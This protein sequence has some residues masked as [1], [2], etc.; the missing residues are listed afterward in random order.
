MIDLGLPPGPDVGAVLR[1]VDQAR[2]EGRVTS[3]DEELELAR[4]LV[5]TRARDPEQE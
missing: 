1:E 5:A 2:A 3:F 4:R